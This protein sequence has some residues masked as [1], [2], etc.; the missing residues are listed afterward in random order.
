M[1]KFDYSFL[2]N[3]LLPVGLI[4]LTSSKHIQ[5]LITDGYMIPERVM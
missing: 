5:I 2:N 4:N 1:R 3:T